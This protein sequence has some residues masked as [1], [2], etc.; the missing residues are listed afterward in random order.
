MSI[1]FQPLP[2]APDALEPVI[3]GRTVR[4]HYLRHHQGYV[5]RLNDKIYDGE[6]DRMSLEDLVH[7]AW[8]KKDQGLF[9][10]AA[11]VWNHNFYWQSLRPVSH[12][13]I[14]RPIAVAIERDFGAFDSFKSR[15]LEAANS[16]F[17]S[18]WVWLVVEQGKLLITRT[19]N[20]ECPIVRNQFPL[21]TID[22]WEHAYYLDYQHDRK[23]YV[24]ECLELLVDWQFA[25]ERLL[26]STKVALSGVT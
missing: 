4:A 15:F 20:A 2:F 7:D 21:F 1:K 9:N 16:Q 25:N 23:E 6:L 24:S 8:S 13:P 11:Q 12:A 19:S 22:V 14:D 17:G 10:L 18:G 26:E 5:N 3:S